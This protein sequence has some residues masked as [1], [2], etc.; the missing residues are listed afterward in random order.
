MAAP[1]DI[2]SGLTKSELETAA[3]LFAGLKDDIEA[4]IRRGNC[5]DTYDDPIY[6]VQKYINDNIAEITKTLA[7][8]TLPANG[9]SAAGG[10]HK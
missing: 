3:K 10:G 4:T 1:K 8:R 5:Y 9:G 7:M 6:L 2:Y